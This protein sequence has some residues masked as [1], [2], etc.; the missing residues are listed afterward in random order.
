MGSHL[1]LSSYRVGMLGILNCHARRVLSFEH[2]AEVFAPSVLSRT[3]QHAGLGPRRR[4]L[5]LLLL[6]PM[7]HVAE[8]PSSLT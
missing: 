6:M 7:K 5:R 1:S 4:L 3:G 2:H 8:L